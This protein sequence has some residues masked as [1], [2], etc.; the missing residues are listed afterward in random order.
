[1]NAQAV[2]KADD[3]AQPQ[4]SARITLASM[5]LALLPE[6]A[7]WGAD[8]RALIV[9]DL[10]L[11]KAAHFAA[12]GQMLPP[13]EARET[14]LRLTRLVDQH[15]PETLVLLGDSFH[16]KRGA[17]ALDAGV[18]AALNHLATRTRHLFITGNHDR[19]LPPLITGQSAATFALGDIT[20]RHE[21]FADG[22]AEIVG[23][24]HPSA[25][26]K[27][28]AGMVRRRCF[29]HTPHRLIL[30]A[31]GSLTGSRDVS[32]PEFAPWLTEGGTAYLLAGGRVHAVNLAHLMH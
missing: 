9:G 8:A 29:V 23:H 10:H 24:L 16:S 27:T 22:Q 20:L 30:P 6:G 18:M 26:L 13:Q 25:R 12:R 7:V 31:F 19:D 28:A 17:A 1:M 3:V 2:C 32:S 11:G 4:G 5:A 15:R 14:L 21:P